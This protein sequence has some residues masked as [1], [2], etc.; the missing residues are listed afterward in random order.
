MHRPLFILAPP[1]SFTS[2]TCGMVGQHPQLLGLPETNLFARDTY[3]DLTRLYGARARFQH[4]LLRS[5]AQLGLGEQT[6]DDIEAAKSWLQKRPSASTAQIFQDLAAWAAPRQLVDKSPLYVYSSSSLERI[7][8][9]FPEAR[10]LHLTRHPRGTCESIVELRERTAERTERLREF[11]TER[12]IDVPEKLQ[13]SQTAKPD[14]D[15]TPE[16][17]WF[18]PHMRIVEFL[19][20]VPEERQLRL[21]GENV[22]SDPDRHLPL[23][24]EWLGLST[25]ADAVEAMKHPEASPFACYGPPNARFG[26]DPSFLEAPALRAYKPKPQ[27]LEA[28]LSWDPELFFGDLVGELAEYFGY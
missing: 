22:L 14:A 27:D 26:N 24:A 18:D 20:G 12:G 8:Q 17:M 6:E 10:Y 23:I 28:P 19:E 11:A 2:V 13:A 5:I 3:A 25:S 15:L 21:R 7:G 1:R 4:G 16:T 9:A